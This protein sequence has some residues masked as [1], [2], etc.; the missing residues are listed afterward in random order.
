ML[1]K[2]P[3]NYVRS[4]STKVNPLFP[5]KQLSIRVDVWGMLQIHLLDGTRRLQ[6]QHIYVLQLCCSGMDAREEY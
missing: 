1:W 6:L 5:G 4:F 3:T 2:L